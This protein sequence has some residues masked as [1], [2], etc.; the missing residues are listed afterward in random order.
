[1]PLSSF[2]KI[3]IGIDRPEDVVVFDDGRVY[4]SCHNCAVA[5]IHDDGSFT[6]LG[7]KTGATNG[8]NATKDGK[9]IIANFGIYDGVA[10]P[11]ESFDPITQT[12]ELLATEV[13]GRALTASNYPIIDN[14]G[15]I[16]SANS[17]SASVWM[18][19]LDGRDDGF[20]YV[21]RPD[22]SSQ[23]LA[24]NLCFPNGLALSAD[25]KYLYCCQTSACN[26]MR[27]EIAYDGEAPALSGR[28]QYGPKLGFR[29]PNA[30]VTKKLPD[31]AL[32]KHLGFI[33]Q[34]VG[35]PDGCGMDVEGNLWV[36]LPGANKIVAIT[37]DENLVII[38]CDPSGN[39]LH[40]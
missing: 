29:L 6:E 38:A 16:Y 19:A 3:A 18:N 7:T 26:I 35:Y 34:Y 13:V 30:M 31:P 33:M 39:H 14:F 8:I 11:L 22:G 23:I 5:Q 15:N 37:P 4:A 40:S 21:V 10:G 27:F 32:T 36:T 1:M 28:R 9:I 17:T 24:D 2:T 20:I 25:G 12:R